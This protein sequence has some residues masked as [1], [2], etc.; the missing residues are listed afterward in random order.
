MDFKSIPVDKKGYDIVFVIIDRLSKQVI[1]LFYYKIVIF[2]DIARLYISMIYYYK[3][4]S[5][6]IVLDRG[7]QF[8]SSFWKEFYRILDIKLKFFI[9]FYFQTDGQ[10]E[11]IN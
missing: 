5:K 11:I 10:T 8:V 6:F 4:P 2:E 9:I 1:S 7:F 3:S